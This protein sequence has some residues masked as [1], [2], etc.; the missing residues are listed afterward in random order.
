VASKVRDES[1]PTFYL[2]HSTLCNAYTARGD[3]ARL[4]PWELAIENGVA[5]FVN[6]MMSLWPLDATPAV[7][8][9]RR[10]DNAPRRKSGAVN[11]R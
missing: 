4:R 7:L 8:L 2:D 10:S 1:E 5:D 11:S 9:E 6:D 3:Y